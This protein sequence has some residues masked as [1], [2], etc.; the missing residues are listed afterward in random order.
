VLI[1]R[2]VNYKLL[3]NKLSL[4]YDLSRDK[5][6]LEIY[7]Q[8]LEQ[9][10]SE[11]TKELSI[12]EKWHRSVF[13]NATDG[14]I[15]LDR[16]GVIIN[17]NQKACEIHGF[18]RDSLVG[19]NIEL[20]ESQGDMERFRERMSRILN[21]ESLIFETEHYQKDGNK[22]ILEV[23]SKA[24]DIGGETF[25]QSFYRDITEKKRIQEQLM[26]SQKMESVGSLAGGI[27]HNFNNILTAILGYS[28][29][30]LEFSDLDDT[31]KQ[32]VRNIESAA[33]KAG[34]M[35]SKLLSFARR[36]SHEVLPLNL[37]DI[38]NDSV[39]L[40]EGVLD[41]R[42]GLK[43]SL[44]DS[45]PFIEG[46]PNQLEQVMMNL[47]VNAR[48]AMPD[49]GL[50]TIQTGVIEASNENIHLPVNIARGKYIVLTIS[51][52]GN[53][54]LPNII[55]R[56][57]D[58]FFTTKEK[59]KGTG[60]GLATVY[61]IVKDHKGY[62]TVQS[63][64]GQGTS[65]DIYL[66]AA[67]KAVQMMAKPKIASVDG[68]E[69]ILLVDDDQ[70]VLNLMRDVLQT[71][72]YRVIPMNNSL[73]ALDVFKSRAEEIQLVITDVIMPLMEGNELIELFR[74]VKPDIKIIA[75]S[76]YSDETIHK[77]GG[78]NA[79]IRKPFESAELL[80]TVRRILDLGARNLPLY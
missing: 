5:E 46:D 67:A 4:E 12:S 50:I 40:F 16:N 11:R 59:G 37:N 27:A 61:G 2:Y 54:I 35:V 19:V 34:V 76:G 1:W 31:S 63:K 10:V 6:Q 39:K 7:S 80:S 23:S 14:I 74:A 44:N 13:D 62:F 33:R 52:T 53:G 30:L 48:D 43:V 79:F 72:G 49:G 68:N 71:R 47:M 22:V 75:V 20:L 51:D 32:R 65:F 3:V 45:I 28:E 25:I 66:P 8:K 18:D 21:G 26:H 29:L 41:K 78:I 64:V 69:S 70:E 24:I 55:D 42:I 77:G 17:V 9:L 36:E 60:L 57:F 38:V 58:P 15:V 73:T 56:I